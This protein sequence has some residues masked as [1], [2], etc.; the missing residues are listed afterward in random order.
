[1]C[2]ANFGFCNNLCRLP[3]KKLFICSFACVFSPVTF[4][5]T[6]RPSCLETSLIC[7]FEI[8]FAYQFRTLLSRLSKLSCVW[9]CSNKQKFLILRILLPSQ[10]IVNL[11]T[12]VNCM[13]IFY[14]LLSYICVCLAA[15][16]SL[17]PIVL[18]MG[19]ARWAS[20]KLL[21]NLSR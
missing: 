19:D 6:T 7:L 16:S 5:V 8:T 11:S 14:C 2:I 4:Q 3:Y 20:P 13:A 9:S 17:A 10:I 18:H 15:Q 1:M 21:E 12:C